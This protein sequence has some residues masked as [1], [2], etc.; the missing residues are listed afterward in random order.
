MQ[1]FW[2]GALQFVVYCIAE[3][4]LWGLDCGWWICIVMHLH[5]MQKKTSNPGNR[6]GEGM[7]PAH[8]TLPWE[9]TSLVKFYGAKVT[10]RAKSARGGHHWCSICPALLTPV[11]ISTAYFTSFNIFTCGSV[12]YLYLRQ[13]RIVQY[14]CYLHVFYFQLSHKIFYRL[15]ECWGEEG[16]WR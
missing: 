14:M 16:R 6:V 9:T 12:P 3:C 2:Y 11:Y 4:C 10:L 15:N 13:L 1:S 7:P 5:H 8:T